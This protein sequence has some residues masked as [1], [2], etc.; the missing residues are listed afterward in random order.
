MNTKN[1]LSIFVIILSSISLQAISLSKSIASSN[2]NKK[3]LS[4]R[5]QDDG[6]CKNLKCNGETWLQIKDKCTKPEPCAAGTNRDNFNICVTCNKNEYYSEKA[7][8]CKKCYGNKVVNADKNGCTQCKN[9]EKKN[10]ETNTCDKKET[11]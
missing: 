3:C 4:Y 10:K 1:L 8:Y 2:G 5:V 6:T 9:D 7:H 11:K